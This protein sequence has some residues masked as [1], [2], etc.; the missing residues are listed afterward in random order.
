MTSI[1]SLWHH[2]RAMPEF[3]G[4][5]SIPLIAAIVTW[6]HVWMA[7]KMVFFPLEF[8]GIAPPWIGWQGIVPRKAGKIG[9]VVVDN[10]LGKLGSI[11]DFMRATNSGQVAGQIIAQYLQQNAEAIAREITDA[12][13]AAFWDRLPAPERER[14]VNAIRWE[15]PLLGVDIYGAI[16]NDIDRYINLRDMVVRRVCEDKGLL[17]RIFREVGKEE[18]AF[19]VNSSFW[20]GMFFGVVQ[21][22]GWYFFPYD[23]GLPAYGAVLGCLTNWV[24]LKLIFEPLEPRTYGVG[25]L[26]WTIQGLFLK[27]QAAVSDIFAKM[28]A[29]EVLTIRN[30]MGEALHGPQGTA[31]HAVIVGHVSP[32]LARVA[33]VPGE[34]KGMAPPLQV[35]DAALAA[36][37]A[38]LLAQVLSMRMKQISSSEFQSLL[39]PAFQEDEWI[40]IF[41]G[42][43]FGLIAGWVQWMI[44]FQ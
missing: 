40:L 17:V 1:V 37:H 23:W 9:G 38:Q 39:R 35:A 30:L 5:V 15:A 7:L 44:G 28:V 8:R 34:E 26:K 3:W 31:T 4:F 11:Q 16:E 24:A 42:S 12:E 10:V 14:R 18:L 6:A 27:R 19:I 36:M 32:F 33:S 20:I 43:V 25:P 29:N 41:L 2:I 21:M 13:S 22:I